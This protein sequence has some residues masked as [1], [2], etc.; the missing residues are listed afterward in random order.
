MTKEQLLRATDMVVLDALRAYHQALGDGR[1]DH[2]ALQAHLSRQCAERLLPYLD[3]YL[4]AMIGE[5]E[6]I[7]PVYEAWYWGQKWTGLV[8]AG[9]V[10]T[11]RPAL[12]RSWVPVPVS[13]MS[14]GLASPS[15]R[16]ETRR[17]HCVV[18]AAP[19]ERAVEAQRWPGL[20]SSRQARGREQPKAWTLQVQEAKPT[21]RDQ[22]M[23][24]FVT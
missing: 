24:S 18:S 20:F 12:T 10:C 23:G 15:P 6:A 13:G 5:D 17:M 2:E 4:R 19:G 11:P 14:S 7:G 16:V 8:P 1:D 22:A 9:I 21:R 3:A